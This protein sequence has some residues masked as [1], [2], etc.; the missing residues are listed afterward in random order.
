MRMWATMIGLII[1]WGVGIFAYKRLIV[2]PTP[3]E[4][5]SD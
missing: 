5:K 2:N 4:K 3:P 1:M